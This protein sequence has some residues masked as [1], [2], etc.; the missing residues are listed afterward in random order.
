MFVFIVGFG[1][2]FIMIWVNV[3]IFLKF[4][5]FNVK[6]EVIVVFISWDFYE[7]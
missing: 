6:M 7:Y 2:E 1:I 4:L 3:L 5:F